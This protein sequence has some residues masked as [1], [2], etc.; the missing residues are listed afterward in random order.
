MTSRFVWILASFAGA[1]GLYLL[2]EQQWTRAIVWLAV[3]ALVVA[4]RIWE[5]RTP[6]L[7]VTP[8]DLILA[9][10]LRAPRRI[11]LS[12][13]E[14]VDDSRPAVLTLVVRDGKN[15]VIPLHWFEWSERP[16]LVATIKAAFMGT[17]T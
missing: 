9:R 16:A 8:R 15:C 11:P 2:Y 13:I 1:N 5:D 4:D 14:R 3:T 10:R 6:L 7:R 17:R 12:T